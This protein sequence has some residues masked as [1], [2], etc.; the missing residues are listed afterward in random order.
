MH[1]I[2]VF[3][4]QDSQTNMTDYTNPHVMEKLQY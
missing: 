2:K 1:S 4:M 3:A